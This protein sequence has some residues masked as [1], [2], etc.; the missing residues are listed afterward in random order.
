MTATIDDTFTFVD[1]IPEA[2]NPVSTSSTLA[3]ETCG[4]PLEYGG[5]GRK[6]RF[7]DEH[8]PSRGKGTGSS[9]RSSAVVDRAISELTLLYSFAG[10]GIAYADHGA[11][12]MVMDAAPKLAESYRM[13]LETNAKF[14]KM[15]A[16]LE[17]KAA[18]LPILVVHGDL[19]AAIL[20]Q[21]AIAAQAESQVTETSL[22]AV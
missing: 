5:R 6:P 15:F 7:C 1:E 22:H 9:A 19:V 8:K 17:G 16:D 18:W 3:C 21:R 10:K 11:G 2:G 12:V 20:L 4:T 13:L 14:R